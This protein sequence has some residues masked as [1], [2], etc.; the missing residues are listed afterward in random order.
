LIRLRK[1]PLWSLVLIILAGSGGV[2]YGLVSTNILSTIINGRT[3]QPDY[4]LSA[5]PPS[6][7]VLQG[8]TVARVTV[9]SVR[10]FT[11]TVSL[12]ATLVQTGS[13]I[14]SVSLSPASV[15]LSANAAGTANLTVNS[16]NVVTYTQP[17]TF[18]VTVTG[19]SGSI[20]HTTGLS[21]TVLTPIGC[22][23]GYICPSTSD[24]L[25]ISISQ[26]STTLQVS[27]ITINNH[28]SYPI[29]LSSY[30][31]TDSYKVQ[32]GSEY[33]LNTTMGANTFQ[34]FISTQPG[35]QVNGIT[36]LWQAPPPPPTLTSHGQLDQ[37]WA[38]MNAQPKESLAFYPYT[39]N[40][41]T[42]VTL[43]VQN[44]GTVSVQFTSYTVK[45]GNGNQYTLNNWNGPTINPT[46]KLSINILIGS[47]CSS[48]TLTG[49]PFS[50]GTADPVTFVTSRG[51]TFT[52]QV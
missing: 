40:S 47:S 2:A 12:S 43:Y 4:S 27:S 49:N 13:N 14:P 3:N 21:V 18:N 16:V 52:A 6:Q 10:G 37:S 45:D 33:M 5:S 20:S 39:I 35:I 29:H 28:A 44:F 34:S 38:P 23:P 7:G 32:I 9:T 46:I 19:N 42:N 22:T 25:S 26:N 15:T 51:N 36:I 8:I 31:Y 1:P 50:F 17:L 24:P 48:C 41:G 11:G 30:F